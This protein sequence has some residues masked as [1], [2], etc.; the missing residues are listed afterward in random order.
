VDVSVRLHPAALNGVKRRFT[1]ASDSQVDQE[2]FRESANRAV[3]AFPG[4]LG[5][6]F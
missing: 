6:S 5:L 2:I 1:Q 3:F 4:L